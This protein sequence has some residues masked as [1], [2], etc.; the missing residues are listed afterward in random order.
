MIDFLSFVILKK[1]R[2]E[3]DNIQ[4][5]NESYKSGNLFI[6]AMRID[7]NVPGLE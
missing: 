4:I 2:K 1:K 5:T 3:K 7:L 6:I